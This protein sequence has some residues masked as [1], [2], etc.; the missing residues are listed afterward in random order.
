MNNWI[1]EEKQFPE[2]NTVVIITDGVN[3]SCGW[4]REEKGELKWG[5][6]GSDDADHPNEL[7]GDVTHWM[8]LPEPPKR[9]G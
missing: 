8:P 5:Y 6:M 4:L 1:E 2:I 3:V 7:H 9:N